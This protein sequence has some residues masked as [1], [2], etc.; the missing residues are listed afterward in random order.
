MAERLEPEPTDAVASD[1]VD[2]KDMADRSR[3]RPCLV[4]GVFGRVSAP[5]ADNGRYRFDASVSWL[6]RGLIQRRLSARNH[7]SP[8]FLAQ[9]TTFL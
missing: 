2:R 3:E 9:I 5:R 4:G 8:A 7:A 1:R 6:A